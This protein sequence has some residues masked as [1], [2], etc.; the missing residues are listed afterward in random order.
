MHISENALKTVLLK[1]H[2]TIS[3]ATCSSKFGSDDIYSLIERDTHAVWVLLGQL[4][5]SLSILFELT[6]S[7]LF[8]YHYVG[9]C[10]LV[11]LLLFSI[12]IALNIYATSYK[13]E[14]AADI[15]S[16][17]NLRIQ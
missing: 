9:V 17:E 12:T 11:A 3:H 5:D 13:T 7:L 16:C 2:F 15:Q 4:P 10:A 6:V 8:V 14:Y 1:K